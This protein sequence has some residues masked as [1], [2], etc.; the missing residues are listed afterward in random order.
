M[1]LA[2]K[3]NPDDGHEEHQAMIWTVA[4]VALKVS[5]AF[6]RIERLVSLDGMI[7]EQHANGRDNP[8]NLEARSI[9]F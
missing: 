4:Q 6:H 7:E 8:S 5:E 2:L 3:Y 1:I 9:L